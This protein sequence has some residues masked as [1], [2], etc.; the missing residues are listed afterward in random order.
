MFFFLQKLL[1]K[2]ADVADESSNELVLKPSEEQVECVQVYN[3]FLSAYANNKI[4]F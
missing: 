3:T 1:S 4:D 2:E